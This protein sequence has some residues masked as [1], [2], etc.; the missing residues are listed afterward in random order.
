VVVLEVE[1]SVLQMLE[2]LVVQA[3]AVEEILVNQEVQELL[4]KDIMVELDQVL[5]VFHQE[6]AVEV[7]L[8]ELE[9]MEPQMEEMVELV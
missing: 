8:L 1:N 4:I 2:A 5:L 7:E 6:A 9:L 3:E